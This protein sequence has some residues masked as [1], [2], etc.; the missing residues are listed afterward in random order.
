MRERTVMFTGT[1]GQGVQIASKTMAVAAVTQG[2]TVLLVPR[3]GGIMRGGKTNAELTIGDG[4]LTALPVVE[5]AWACF[6]MD[7]SYWR[8]VQD[9]LADDAVMLLNSSL[10]HIE[11]PLPAPRVYRVPATETAT[12]LGSPMSAAMVM[13]GAFVSL[14]GIVTMDAVAAAMRDLIPAYRTQHIAANER[15]LAA[16]AEAVPALAEP[17]WTTETIR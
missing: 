17:A 15:A 5:D 7:Q 4:E 6:A 1:G 8:S 14:T 16:G 3:Y 9:H 13:L 2:R 12:E 11:V 10:F